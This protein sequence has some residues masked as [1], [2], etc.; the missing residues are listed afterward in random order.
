MKI[1]AFV[2]V[3]FGLLTAAYGAVGVVPKY[4]S[5]EREW[6]ASSSSSP[7]GSSGRHADL[8][9]RR[10]ELRSRAQSYALAAGATAII[11]IILALIGR[12][13]GTFPTALVIGAAVVTLGLTGY[14]Q[15]AGN[16]F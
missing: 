7:Y 12:K 2:I 6:M 9:A 5:V 13:K 16:I 11:G 4:Q 14:M 10:D 3:L 15:A 8:D 1:L